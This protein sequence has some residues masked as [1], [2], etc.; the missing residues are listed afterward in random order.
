MTAVLYLTNYW[1]WSGGLAVYVHWVTGEPIPDPNAPGRKHTGADHMNFAARFYELPEAQRLYR[2]HVAKLLERRN[3]INGRRYVDDPAIMAWQLANEPRPGTDDPQS[4]LRLPAF[5]QWLAEAAQFIKTQA[6]RHLVSTGSEGAIGCLGKTDACRQAHASPAID[7]VT[8][9]LWVKNWGW[10]TE[11]WLGPQYESAVARA[12]E[13]VRLHQDLSA[14]LGKPLVMEEFGIGRDRESTV[15]TSPTT[16][17]DDYYRRMFHQLVTSVAA[18]QPLQAANFWVWSGEPER[19]AVSRR[20]A[21]DSPSPAPVD[22]NGVLTTDRST[23]QVIRE[24]NA[25]LAD[26]SR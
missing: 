26:L 23:R 12:M 5:H 20:V 9:H 13:H 7:Y 24:Y 4:E 21:K 16:M 22:L 17:R 1:E 8:L 10:L 25:R 19:P 14:Q 11:P 15:P 3:S 2:Q 6:P 18:G